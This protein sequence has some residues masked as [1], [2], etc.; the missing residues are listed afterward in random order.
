MHA[1]EPV[2]FWSKGNL[3]GFREMLTELSKGACSNGEPLASCINSGTGR[4][5]HIMRL[6]RLGDEVAKHVFKNKQL[7]NTGRTETVTL[8]ICRRGRAF[9]IRGIVS[10]WLPDPTVRAQRGERAMPLSTGRRPQRRVHVV[11][12]H[13]H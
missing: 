6:G 5:Q 11:G 13:D 4:V 3:Q 8:H 12:I 10:L 1:P 2:S 7:F 9:S